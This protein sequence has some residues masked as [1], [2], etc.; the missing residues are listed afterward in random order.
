MATVPPLQAAPPGAFL[1]YPAPP[2]SSGPA[3]GPSPSRVGVAPGCASASLTPPNVSAAS[4][5]ADAQRHPVG[6]GNG[7]LNNANLALAC[8]LD[9]DAK[10]STS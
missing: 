8:R 4:L 2:P 3:H 9:K 7:S 6:P 10:V 5:E 1:A